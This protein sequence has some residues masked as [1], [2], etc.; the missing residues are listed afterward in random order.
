MTPTQSFEAARNAFMATRARNAFEGNFDAD[1]ALAEFWEAA[2]KAKEVETA[3]LIEKA[4]AFLATDPPCGCDTSKDDNG[5]D[6]CRWYQ[7]KQALAEIKE[8]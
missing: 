6:N 8:K 1:E 4:E 7:F 3:G 5:L 2:Q